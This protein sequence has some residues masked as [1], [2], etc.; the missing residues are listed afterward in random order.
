MDRSPESWDGGDDL[1]RQRLKREARLLDLR[2]VELPEL[3]LADV[4]AEV[5][6]AQAAE[7]GPLDVRE[8]LA[9]AGHNW[10]TIDAVA[11]YLQTQDA[12]DV[13]PASRLP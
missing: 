2:L 13:H 11:H 12:A 5:H 6:A 10:R 7:P 8:Y 1:A 3:T 4:M 9:T